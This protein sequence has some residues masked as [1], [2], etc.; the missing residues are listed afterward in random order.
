MK[1]LDGV[2]HFDKLEKDLMDLKSSDENRY[3]DVIE[4]LMASPTTLYWMEEGDE[5]KKG[6][7]LCFRDLFI[8]GLNMKSLK[9]QG[10]VLIHTYLFLF[11]DTEKN[12]SKQQNSLYIG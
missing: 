4:I 5:G 1:D 2:I 3:L 12:V 8:R 9:P 6:A 10:Y 7:D 11:S